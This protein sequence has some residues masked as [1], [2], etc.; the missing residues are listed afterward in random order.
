MNK[1]K[2]KSKID[3]PPNIFHFQTKTKNKEELP[4]KKKKR[5][6]EHKYDILNIHNEILE[7]FNQEYINI[8]NMKKEKEKAKWIIENTKSNKEYL[9][10]EERYNHLENK[11]RII[12]G[13]IE[14]ARYLYQSEKILS[15]YQDLMEKPIEINFMG[16]KKFHIKKEK[17]D[18]IKQYIN[19]AKN[20]ITIE[21]IIENDIINLCEVCEVPMKT[22]DDLLLVCPECGYSYKNLTCVSGFQENSRINN[23]QRYTYE[24]E[25]HFLD[26]IKKY[27]GKQNTTIPD[28]VYEDIRKKVES[29]DIPYEKLKKDH[30]YEFLKSTKNNDY[31]EDINLIYS[32]LTGIQ[33]PDISH[34]EEELKSLFKEIDKIYEEVKPPGRLNFLNG[35]YV[36]FRFLQKLKYPCRTED[37]SILKTR[38]KLLEYEEIWKK[39]CQ[40]K[41]WT[42]KALI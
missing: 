27:Q 16:T 23:A 11:I 25:I 17:E 24:K 28:K 20:Y 30:I 3:I 19:V 42:Y 35:Q 21:P 33:P 12:E 31:Y 36:L 4:K 1:Q 10:A 6:K 40:R 8:D 29:H 2:C 7:Q 38:D 9:H 34:L 37:F 41:N 18:L 39:I 26:A 13:G 14:L 32:Q 22:A 5:R 15:K